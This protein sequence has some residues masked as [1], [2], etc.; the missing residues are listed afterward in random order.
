MGGFLTPRIIPVSNWLATPIYKPFSPFGRGL[1]LLRGPILQAG[2]NF[3]EGR[4][5][6]VEMKPRAPQALTLQEGLGF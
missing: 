6:S 2:G 3:F 5:R 1:T 4:C